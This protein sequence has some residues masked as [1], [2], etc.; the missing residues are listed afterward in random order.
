MREDLGDLRITR[1]RPTELAEQVGRPEQHGCPLMVLLGRGAPAQ[2]LDAPR[3]GAL[4]VG[5]AEDGP[6]LLQLSSAAWMPKPPVKTDSRAHSS[7]AAVDVAQAFVR[8]I[9]GIDTGRIYA[10]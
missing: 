6:G 4:I 9:E 8:S 7:V 5:Q 2:V 3:D 10:V 1:R